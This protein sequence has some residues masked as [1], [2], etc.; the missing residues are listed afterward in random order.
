MDTTETGDVIF[1][2]FAEE[3]FSPIRFNGI[4]FQLWKRDH[5]AQD[6]FWEQKLPQPTRVLNTTSQSGRL[7]GHN[8]KATEGE[9]YS[10]SRATRLNTNAISVIN[11]H[12]L[13]TIVG[14]YDFWL[15]LLTRDD[16]ISPCNQ[17]HRSFIL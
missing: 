7:S 12:Q 13:I 5:N 14:M 10:H 1:R 4:H 11:E 3:T 2:P 9:F 17:I 15:N 8:A 6:G 16:I